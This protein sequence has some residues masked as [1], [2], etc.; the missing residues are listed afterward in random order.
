MER[1]LKPAS[2]RSSGTVIARIAHALLLREGELASSIDGG[3]LTLEKVDVVDAVRVLA[4]RRR[5][6]GTAGKKM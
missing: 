1:A 2:R 3:G 4:W 5:E 6:L